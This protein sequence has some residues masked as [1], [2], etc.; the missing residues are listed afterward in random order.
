VSRAEVL[1]TPLLAVRD[2]A[3]TYPGRRGRHEE[4]RAVDGVSFDI[5]QGTTVALVGESGSGKTTIGNAILGVVRP[6]RGVIELSGSKIVDADV[7]ERHT[8]SERIQVVF[9]DPY[10][11]LNPSRTIAQTL[12]E[13][14]LGKGRRVKGDRGALVLQALRSV[15]LPD[16]VATRY[17]L[18]FSGGQRQRIAVA[19]ATV[20]KPD[21]IILDEPVSSLDLSVQAQILNLISEMQRV[22]GLSYL[23]ISHDLAVVR[24]MANT[25]VILYRGRVVECGPAK[26]VTD[27]PHHPYSVALLN[28]APVP[29][30]EVQKQRRIV[31]KSQI[32]SHIGVEVAS[33]GCR[34]AARCPMAIKLCSEVEPELRPTPV[35]TFS[36]CHR[37][38]DVETVLPRI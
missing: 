25:I 5:P 35:G 18:Q 22:E 26:S 11:S 12:V 30:P 2:L 27:H 32:V 20:S 34:F 10:G 31:R 28:A 13:P 37:L 33:H 36:A 16:E 15:G 14:L 7:V 29:D 24:R 23:F 1:S 38:H 3:V 19:R 6:S 4:V 9:Q 17:P 21:L 8:I